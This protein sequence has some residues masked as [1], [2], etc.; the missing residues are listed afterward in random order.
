MKVKV[1]NFIRTHEGVLGQVIEVTNNQWALVRFERKDGNWN[2]FN[3]W[4]KGIYN[5]A[6]R[7]DFLCSKENF[8]VTNIAWESIA[9]IIEF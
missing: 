1:G 3:N 5:P 6:E 9:L 8:Y 7:K 4:N 2:R